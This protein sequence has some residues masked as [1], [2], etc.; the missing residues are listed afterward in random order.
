MA[1]EKQCEFSHSNNDGDRNIRQ[2][3]TVMEPLCEEKSRPNCELVLSPVCE[4]VKEQ[5]CEQEHEDVA[6][7]RMAPE[8]R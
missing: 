5:V 2:C 3:E 6:E 7:S 1:C 4:P 8:T